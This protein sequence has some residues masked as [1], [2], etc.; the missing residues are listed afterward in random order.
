MATRDGD[1]GAEEGDMGRVRQGK[2]VGEK[3]EVRKKGRHS[4][5]EGGRTG[6][7]AREWRTERGKGGQR[8]EREMGGVKE[9]PVCGALR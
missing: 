6:G 3:D 7:R 8:E 5:R 2:G 1:Q 4:T 9:Q